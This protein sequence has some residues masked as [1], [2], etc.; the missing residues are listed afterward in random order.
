MTSQ[1]A[2]ILDFKVSRFYP[3]LNYDTENDEKTA[4]LAIKIYKIVIIHCSCQYLVAISKSTH[5]LRVYNVI[6]CDVT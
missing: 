3:N 4:Y 2:A 6:S 1:V 5:K